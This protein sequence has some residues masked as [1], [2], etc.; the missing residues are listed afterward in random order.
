MKKI[1]ISV[2][3]RVNEYRESVALPECTIAS[4]KTQSLES[5]EK[6]DSE[7]FDLYKQ[8]LKKVCAVLE[9]R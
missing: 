3:I 8:S 7:A 4:S 5:Y 6:I 9:T 2:T 1:E